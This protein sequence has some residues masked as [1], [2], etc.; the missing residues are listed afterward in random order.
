MM[1]GFLGRLRGR[2]SAVGDLA[3]RVG[4]Q[5]TETPGWHRRLTA[6]T[7]FLLAMFLAMV[8]LL[9]RREGIFL[10]SPSDE[11]RGQAERGQVAPDFLLPELTGTPM[12]L[13]D[14]REKVVLLNFWAT[15][16]LPCR[17]EMPWLVDFQK[18]YGSQGLQIVGV[19]MDDAEKATIVKFADEMKLNYPILQGTEKAGDA[20]GGVQ[21][22]PTTFYIARDGR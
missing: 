14:H 13:L 18:Q 10:A 12:R 21:A 3:A 2:R 7:V 1:M 17:S 15:W 19:A 11:I 6:N 16:C 22:L 4:E 8:F 20:Y 5:E 9:V